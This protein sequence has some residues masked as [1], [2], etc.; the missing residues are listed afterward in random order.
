MS[1]DHS[2]V[3]AEI[4]YLVKG[5]LELTIGDETTIAKSP[6]KIVI[7]SNEHHKLLALSDVEILEDRAGE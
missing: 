6:A 4:L 5:E 3:D 1:A 7:N 2:H